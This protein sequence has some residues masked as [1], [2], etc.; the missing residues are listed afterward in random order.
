MPLIEIPEQLPSTEIDEEILEIFVEDIEQIRENIARFFEV[1]KNDATDSES[2]ENLQ[3]CFHALKS[4]GRLLGATT[5]RELGWHFENRLN[6]ITEGLLSRNDDLLTLIKQVDKILPN[7]LEQFLHHQQTPYEVILFISQVRHLTLPQNEQEQIEEIVEKS[8]VPIIPLALQLALEGDAEEAHEIIEIETN[9]LSEQET[10]PAK[11]TQNQERPKEIFDNEWGLLEVDLPNSGWQHE[12]IFENVEELKLPEAEIE[13]LEVENLSETDLKLTPP[14]QEPEFETVSSLDTS[15]SLTTFEENEEDTDQELLDIFKMEATEHLERLDHIL[16]ALEPKAPIPLEQEVIRIFHTLKGSSLSIG[17]GEIA[18]VAAPVEKYTRT[19]H[20]QQISISSDIR[21]LLYEARKLIGNL[22][23]NQPVKEKQQNIL[24]DNIQKSLASYTSQKSRSLEKTATISTTNII[25]SS[26][27]DTLPK[28]TDEFITIFL[29]EADEILENTQSLLE[30]WIAA[31]HNKVFIKELQ[32]ELHTLKGGARMVGIAPIGD[33]SHHLES[34]LTQ[35]VEGKHQPTIS[36][37]Q[38]VLQQSVDELASMLET[39]HNH[40]PLSLPTKLIQQ[41]DAILAKKTIVKAPPTSPPLEKQKP[42]QKEKWTPIEKQRVDKEVKKEQE[43]KKEALEPT[44]STED[45]LKV[46]VTLIDMLTN[47]AGELSISNAQM[48]QQQGEFKNHLME[49][50][51]TVIRLRGQLRKLEIETEAQIRSFYSEHLKREPLEPDNKE[52]DLL[53]LDRFSNLQQLS[54]SMTE[55]VSDLSNIQELLKTLLRQGDSQLIQQNRIGTDLQEGIMRTRMIPF[56]KVS[57]RLQRMT[58]LTAKELRKQANL[59]IKGENIEFEKTVLEHIVAPIEHIL[60]NAV[61][62]GIEDTKVRH[63]LGKTPVGKITIKIA[64]EGAELIIKIGDDGAGLNLEMIRQK[65]EERGLIKPKTPIHEQELMNFIL[66]PSFSTSKTVTQVS[67]RGVGM[68]IVQNEIKQLGGSLQ[69]H[70]KRG[71][72]TTFEI[73]L[74]VSLS[75]TQALIVSIGEET[76]AVPLNYLDAVIHA[77]CDQV[78]SEE[79]E[80]RYCNYMDNSYS[81]FYLG[82]LLGFNKMTPIDTDWI[83]TLLIHAADRRIALLVDT[84]KGIREIALKSVGPQISTL[85]WIVGATILGD[86]Q[87]A[88]ILDMSAIVQVETI[89]QYTLPEA[90]ETEIIQEETIPKTI[91]VVDDSI[92]VRKVTARFLKRQG[93]EVLTAKDGFDAIAQLQKQVPDLL[94]LDVE[95]P[96][97]D[98]YELATQVRNNQEWEEIPI[99]MVTSRTGVKHRE[100]ADKIGINRYLGKPY[101]ENELLENINVLLD[102]TTENDHFQ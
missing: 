12:A 72:G 96:R 70:S 90:T 93:L 29:E 66:Y 22:L 9:T 64:M 95:M 43:V 27:Q 68:D 30:R 10:K 15:P 79:E 84:I 74:P 59:I 25:S 55:S 58:R 19:L 71:E 3:H 31:P 50:E 23:N 34:V 40:L 83:P 13:T 38:E 81:V 60:R 76:M 85:P 18:E 56:G 53:E 2:L 75:I 24:L 7:L 17:F 80:Q 63:Q 69:I 78:I 86:G 16:K 100:K 39:I 65:A 54:R 101:T 52:F 48:Q 97:M 62:H 99:I 49:M 92:T 91:M 73:H 67:G 51:Q 6:Q 98:G 21:A 35:I 82:E 26:E 94:L 44:E 5:I 77:P 8:T 89:S 1:W 45:K 87:I 37:L 36:F 32:R 102:E 46:R 57:S 41:I 20:E 88:L 28:V 4:K 61:G 47:L 33:L 14:Q 42:V 11:L